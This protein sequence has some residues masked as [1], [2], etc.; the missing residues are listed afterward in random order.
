MFTFPHWAVLPQS[1]TGADSALVITRPAEANHFKVTIVPNFAKS[2]L[3]RKETVPGTFLSRPGSQY[4]Y[5][6]ARVRREIKHVKYLQSGLQ[7]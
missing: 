5:I 7:A 4:I 6:V 1:G 3:G 2:S